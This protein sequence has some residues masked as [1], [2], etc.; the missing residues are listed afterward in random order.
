[1]SSIKNKIKPKSH[2]T[3]YN[4]LEK[5]VRMKILKPLPG[6]KRNR[7]YIFPELLKILEE[8]KNHG[9]VVKS[10]SIK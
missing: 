8:T 3:I 2:Q 1:F 6:R 4:L 9:F 10:K 7:I 5:F